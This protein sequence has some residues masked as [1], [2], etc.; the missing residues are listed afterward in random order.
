MSSVSVNTKLKITNT[1]LFVSIVTLSTEH[2]V[3]LTK[4]LSET[5][6]RSVYWNQCKIERTTTE[7]DNNNPVK[8]MLDAS[9]NE[10]KKLFV[11]AFNG[12]AVDADNNPINNAK[13][14]VGRRTKLQQDKE[15]SIP[16]DVC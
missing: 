1:K 5:F 2:N 10:V 11:L 3:K 9:F 4:Q 12:T 7:I 16:R 6:K 8:V 14:R 15:V 13:N